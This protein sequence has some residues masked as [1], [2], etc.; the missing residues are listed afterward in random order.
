MM[1]CTMP[2]KI[3]GLAH[4]RSAWIYDQAHRRPAK[5]HIMI[6]IKPANGR[7]MYNLLVVHGPIIPRAQHNTGPELF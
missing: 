2:A 1:F 4:T 7:P 6:H 3:H 5:I